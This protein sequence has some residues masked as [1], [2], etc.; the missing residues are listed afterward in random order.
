MHPYCTASTCQTQCEN[1]LLDGK[2][3]LR[4]FLDRADRPPCKDERRAT[5]MQVG[6]SVLTKVAVTARKN[7]RKQWKFK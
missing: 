4:Y 3:Q 2:T 5:P 1:F 7:F 6:I